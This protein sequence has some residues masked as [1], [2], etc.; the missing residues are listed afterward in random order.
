PA[1]RAAALVDQPGLPGQSL[2]VLGDPDQVAH[3]AADVAAGEHAHPA[4]VAVDL[5][6]VAAQPPGHRTGVQ[7]GLDDHPAAHDVQATREAQQ[8]RDL[9]LALGGLRALHP[10][11]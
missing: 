2:T 4:R 9:R 3:A 5:A 1:D 11:E 10:G 8:R 6:D 7:L